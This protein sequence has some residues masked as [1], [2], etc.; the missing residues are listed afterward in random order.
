MHLNP[1]VEP[2]VLEAVEGI[3]KRHVQETDELSDHFYGKETDKHA[4]DEEERLQQEVEQHVCD[5]LTDA[6]EGL[7]FPTRHLKSQI[8]N[9]LEPDGVDHLAEHKEGK[10]PER[11][12]HRGEDELQPG[13]DVSMQGR[14][15]NYSR[16]D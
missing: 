8:C 14:V 15:T 11:T 3:E 7:R 2:S 1:F 16:S 6:G 4:L 5:D 12:E 10:D 9:V 13:P